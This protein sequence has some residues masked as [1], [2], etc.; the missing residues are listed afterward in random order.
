MPGVL[1]ANTENVEESKKR[2][3]ELIEETEKK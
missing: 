1:K 2:K 3:L